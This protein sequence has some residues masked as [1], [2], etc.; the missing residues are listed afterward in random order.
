MW[1]IG[2]CW[3]A[4]ACSPACLPCLPDP[5]RRPVPTFRCMALSAQFCGHGAF[6]LKA[7]QVLYDIDPRYRGR[8]VEVV[9]VEA[10]RAVCKCGPRQFQIRLSLISSD[11]EP[12]RS[13][14]TTVA[15]NAGAGPATNVSLP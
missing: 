15:P 1:A 14:Y 4:A 13:G 3:S 7:G 8:K 5:S 6:M 2:S 12:R 9:R 11:G 10:S